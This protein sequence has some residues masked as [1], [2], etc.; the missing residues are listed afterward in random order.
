MRKK[1]EENGHTLKVI[2]LPWPRCVDQAKKGLV[3][4]CWPSWPSDLIDTGLVP[5]EILYSSNVGIA[6]HM[7][8]PVSIRSLLDLQHVRLG[9]VQD[10]GYSQDYVE[11]VRSGVLK[12]EIV[13][14]DIQN[15]MKLYSNRIDVTILDELNFRYWMLLRKDLKKKIRI[16][17]SF[18]GS[19]DLV[20]GMSKKSA[21]ELGDLVVKIKKKNPALDKEFHLELERIL[22]VS[23]PQK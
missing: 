11:L 10:Y 19:K 23:A 12:P 5:S 18:L 8:R 21:N 9:A 3:D 20:I 16:H 4:G 17:D 13:R 6:E 7:D 1:I 2:F 15:L 22:K 14:T